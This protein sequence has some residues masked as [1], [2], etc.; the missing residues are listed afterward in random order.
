M[1]L[2]DAWWMGLG[3]VSN[4]GEQVTFEAWMV[5][6]CINVRIVGTRYCNKEKISNLYIFTFYRM[7]L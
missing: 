2:R 4:S 3:D 7:L 5:E 1:D 6:R